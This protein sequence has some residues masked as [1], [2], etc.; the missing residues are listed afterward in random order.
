M[1]FC[2][3]LNFVTP[4]NKQII[5][6]L[7][8]LDIIRNTAFNKLISAKKKLKLEGFELDS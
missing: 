4:K 3:I 8:S 1:I 7:S 5:V 6:K 2:K